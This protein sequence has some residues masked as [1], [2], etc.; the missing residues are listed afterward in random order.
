MKVWIARDEALGRSP[1]LLCEVYDRKPN[2][3]KDR[4]CPAFWITPQG[5][6]RLGHVSVSLCRLLF[7]VAPPRV[8]GC[9][10]VEVRSK[11]I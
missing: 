7:G 2:K 4:G 5:G 6:R 8:G 11:A 1:H 3:H 9:V 10:C